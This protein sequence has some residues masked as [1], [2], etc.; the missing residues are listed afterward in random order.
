M[1]SRSR[2]AAGGGR[3][4]AMRGLNPL[5][6]GGSVKAAR[7]AAGFALDQCAADRFDFRAAFLAAPDQVADVLAIAAL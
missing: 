2:S 3:Y 5:F 4:S 1:D 7:L 6:E